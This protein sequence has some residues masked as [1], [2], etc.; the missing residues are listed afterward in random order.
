MHHPMHIL[1]ALSQ[2]RRRNSVPLAS[3]HSPSLHQWWLPVTPSVCLHQC[4]PS[5]PPSCP[6]PTVNAP[7]QWTQQADLAIPL[8]LPQLPSCPQ[9][10]CLHPA[11]SIPLLSPS[12]PLLL[13]A[14]SCSSRRVL[15][16]HFASSPSPFFPVPQSPPTLDP[17]PPP[18][19]KSTPHPWSSM[20]QQAG[21]SLRSAGCPLIFLPLTPFSACRISPSTPPSS[22]S[23]PP[24]AARSSRWNLLCPLHLP[25]P[26]PSLSPK[27]L[28]PPN[29]LSLP[30]P[31][32]HPPQTTL[33]PWSSMEQQ[34]G[35][36]TAGCAWL[37]FFPGP[38][39]VGRSVGPARALRA[40]GSAWGLVSVI[41]FLGCF[42][43]WRELAPLM[44]VWGCWIL[45]G[46]TKVCMQDR[47]AVGVKVGVLQLMHLMHVRGP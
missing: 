15:F 29:Y 32:P 1:H 18:P 13:N 12:H 10:P 36:R 26:P 45:S 6:P 3:L 9:K 24:G 4:S 28:R 14:S 44:Q 34:A 33:P 2:S 31:I 20:E 39:S 30:H 16:L 47:G 46:G 19:P 37:A 23:S 21:L 5:C 7:F 22:Q 38:G 27:P 17:L 40:L 43:Q 25:H 42:N 35:S 8:H 11:V 41:A